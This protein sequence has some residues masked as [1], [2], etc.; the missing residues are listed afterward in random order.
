MN[1]RYSLETAYGGV[2]HFALEADGYRIDK[3]AFHTKPG[4]ESCWTPVM[5]DFRQYF[6][7]GRDILRLRAALFALQ[8]C[9]GK[10]GGEQTPESHRDYS[11]FYLLYLAT[12]RQAL[13]PVFGGHFIRESERLTPEERERVAGLVRREFMAGYRTPAGPFDREVEAGL[14]ADRA[15]LVPG[16]DPKLANRPEVVFVMSLNIHVL[17]AALYIPDPSHILADGIRDV[18]KHMDI[19]FGIEN[20]LKA[21][22]DT[23]RITDDDHRNAFYMYFLQMRL[24]RDQGLVKD[25]SVEYSMLM[26]LY[27]ELYRTE[28]LP[29]FTVEPFASRWKALP[30]SVKE[31]RAEHF[32]KRLSIAREQFK[33]QVEREDANEQK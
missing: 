4:E 13:P 14:A 1:K 15:E 25:G 20:E 12:Y 16:M 10:W 29:C 27:L 5:R 19:V 31:D 8:R 11:M 6:Y 33:K 23:A 24:L 32:R 21:L 17:A 9:F 26:F 18:K 22:C 3:V 28:L 30:K 7:L 2:E